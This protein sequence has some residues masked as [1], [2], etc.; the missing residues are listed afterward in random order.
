MKKWIFLAGSIGLIAAILPMKPVSPNDHD[1]LDLGNALIPLEEI[2]SGGP[3]KDGIPSLTDPRFL[4]AN[5]AHY[6]K[7]DDRVLGI[8]LDGIAKAYPLQILIWHEAI[9]D[10]L[11]DR[12]V[13][14]TY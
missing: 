14:A 5:E 6:L 1:E 3:P 9:N 7:P 2:K 12:P 4:P 10:L 8:F 11:G 13:L